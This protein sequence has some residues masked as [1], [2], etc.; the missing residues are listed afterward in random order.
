MRVIGRFAPTPSGALHFGSLIAAVGSFVSA[1]RQGGSWL[2]R[3]EDIDRVRVVRGATAAILTQLEAYGLFWD[4][5]VVYQSERL[6]AYRQALELL[7][8][9]GLT[10]SCRCSRKALA[11]RPHTAQC[12]AAID[13]TAPA[14]TRIRTTDE[15]ISFCD[16]LCG[17]VAQCVGREVGDFV[18]WRG[19]EPSYQLAV[20][21]DDAAFGISEVVRGADLLDSTPRQIYLQRLLA[22]ATPAYTHLPLVLGSDGAKLSK[23]NLAQPIGIEN[24]A[25]TMR[26]ALEFLGFAP[27]PPLAAAAPVEQ[28]AWAIAQG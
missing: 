14:A 2:L 12:T 16:R 10:Y 24:R 9:Q 18:L 11:G 21:V 22:L 13:R 6:E 15:T 17:E 23:Q 5:A 4:G 7:Q 8:K 20:V 1:K 25:E 19:A 3:I 26:K 28:L 27:P